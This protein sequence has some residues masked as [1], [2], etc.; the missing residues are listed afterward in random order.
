MA[1]LLEVFGLGAHQDDGFLEVLGID[2][3][4]LE[5]EWRAYIGAPAR[6]GETRATP[7][8]SSTPIPRPTL[9]MTDTPMPAATPQSETALTETPI[10]PPT[11]SPTPPEEAR[12]GLW[13][14]SALPGAALLGLFLVFGPRTNR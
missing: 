2:V 12:A 3:D 14:L 8:S 1:R 13:C 5:D 11:A 7:V 4:G 6:H 10:P 9:V